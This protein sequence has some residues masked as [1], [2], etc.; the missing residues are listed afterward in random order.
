MN[1]IAGELIDGPN[2][3]QF[4][5]GELAVPL[6]SRPLATVGNRPAV[7]GARPEDV[8]VATL[9]ERNGQTPAVVR[10]IEKSGGTTF[11]QIFINGQHIG[12]CDDLHALERAGKLD[13]MLAA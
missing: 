11:P 6:A 9:G 12:G 3:A 13:V 10:V 7:L 2:G 1:F 5:R 8:H 4:R